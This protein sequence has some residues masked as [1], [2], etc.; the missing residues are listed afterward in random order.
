LS[1]R[2]YRKID[3]KDWERE[4]NLSTRLYRKVEKKD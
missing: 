1:T 3:K 4:R 2:L